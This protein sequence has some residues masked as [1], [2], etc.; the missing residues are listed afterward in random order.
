MEELHLNFLLIGAGQ[1][2]VFLVTALSRLSMKPGVSALGNFAHIQEKRLLFFLLTTIIAD[3]QYS[4]IEGAREG[5]DIPYALQLLSSTVPLCC[6]VMFY[7]YLAIFLVRYVLKNDGVL[8]SELGT[9]SF[10]SLSLTTWLI[11]LSIDVLFIFRGTTALSGFVQLRG[12]IQLVFMFILGSGLLAIG[13][14]LWPEVKRVRNP[15]ELEEPLTSDDVENKRVAAVRLPATGARATAIPNRH[16]QKMP[17]VTVV[18][19][20]YNGSPTQSKQILS[21]GFASGLAG[22]FD[23]LPPVVNSTITSINHPALPQ[24]S[25]S[26]IPPPNNNNNNVSSSSSRFL[27]PVPPPLLPPPSSSSSPS[28]HSA[29]SH[30]SSSRSKTL[31]SSPSSLLHQALETSARRHGS[32]TVRA[33]HTL[34]EAAGGSEKAWRERVWQLTKAVSVCCMGFYLQILLRFL[35]VFEWVPEN[36]ILEDVNCFLGKLL[37]VLFLLSVLRKPWEIMRP[38]QLSDLPVRT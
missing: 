33:A 2:L 21:S 38:L 22:S 36:A 24:A 11:T 13:C 7:A 17:S 37:P 23:S 18:S 16:K 4:F 12:L 20:L 1:I 3:A 9:T 27:S 10:A 30:S 6:S 29:R 15:S 26:S 25:T 14:C 28:S 8:D 19:D 32:A 35:V 31:S 5:K 34:Q